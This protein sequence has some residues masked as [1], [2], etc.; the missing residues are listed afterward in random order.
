MTEAKHLYDKRVADIVKT[1]DFCEPD[2]IPVMGMFLTWPVGY[3]GMNL[4]E[5]L[6]KP[7]EL[8]E[9]WC[10]IYDEVY[11]D[12]THLCGISTSIRTLQALGSDTFF[13]SSDGS[14]IQHKEN[15]KMLANEYD[16]LMKDPKGFMLNVLGSR[17]FEKLSA[18]DD[19]SYECLVNAAKE[20][21]EFN[22]INS[23]I[24]EITINKY[25]I[26]F[27]YGN[28]KVYP[29]FDYIFDRLRGFSGTMTDMRRNRA[30]LLEATNVMYE[31]V[32]A[33]ANTGNK[34][35][36]AL[37]SNT[38]EDHGFPY[39]VSTV[40]CPTYLSPKDYAELYFP[41]F[42]LL[43]ETI[44]ESGSKTVLFNEGGWKKFNDI[45][46]ELPKKST[47]SIYEE[48]D[49]VEMKHLM[50]E[51]TTVCGGVKTNMLKYASKQ[52]C[53]DEAKRVC[54]ECA[55]G[56]GFMFTTERSLLS[57]GD[58]NIENLAAVNEFV[59]NYKR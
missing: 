5:M 47:I 27:I 11:I 13:I 56:G 39:A 19:A 49:I 36:W 48:D 33:W 51:D 38:R 1:T 43:L 18:G 35:G 31:Y 30:K 58:V 17:K 7:Q 41:T 28:A 46:K 40:H 52:E 45:M 32:K 22:K 37:T 14:T 15:C 20:Q 21:I 34:A 10:K 8:A 26:T 44:Y 23:S 42:K 9:K 16:D 29:P 59:H 54:D 4:G 53:L 57:A 3:Y 25:G 50:G 12:T 24:R 55:P 2:N 6:T